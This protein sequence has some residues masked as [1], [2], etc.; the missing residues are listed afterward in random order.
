MTVAPNADY[1]DTPDFYA[2]HGIADPTNPTWEDAARILRDAGAA[3]FNEEDDCGPYW[4]RA[5]EIYERVAHD[6]Q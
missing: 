4:A 1:A 5:V 6:D 3:L 2:M